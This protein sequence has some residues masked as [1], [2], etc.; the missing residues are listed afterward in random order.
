MSSTPPISTAAL[1]R[2]GRRLRA[3][4]RVQH[5][6]DAVGALAVLGRHCSARCAAARRAPQI[7]HHATARAGCAPTRHNQPS[8]VGAPRR[9]PRAGNFR[10]VLLLMMSAAVL[11]EL[12]DW[13]MARWVGCFNTLCAARRA[14]P[15]TDPLHARMLT[16][17][18]G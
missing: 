18:H 13:N 4:A 1:I 16:S 12:S 5:R 6:A 3:C 9:T 2:C 11:G 10:T 15:R 8:G 14:G 17:A 7:R